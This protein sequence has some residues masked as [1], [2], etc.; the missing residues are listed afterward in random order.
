MVAADDILLDAVLEPSPRGF[1]AIGLLMG[2]NFG[3]SAVTTNQYYPNS[4][5]LKPTV[6]YRKGSTNISRPGTGQLAGRVEGAGLGGGNA[7][8]NTFWWMRLCQDL[9]LRAGDA[10]CWPMKQKM[11]NILL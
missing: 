11:N 4:A 7:A 10:H 5:R 9:T 1:T 2:I 3:N 8:G 6:T